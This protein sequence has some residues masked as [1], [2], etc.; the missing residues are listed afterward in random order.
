MTRPA[1]DTHDARDRVG[2]RT[3]PSWHKEP[4]SAERPHE[5]AAALV[6]DRRSFPRRCVA[7]YPTPPP[8]G[9]ATDSG[10]LPNAGQELA[11]QAEREGEYVPPPWC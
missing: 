2:V 9:V 3:E 7:T 5:T 8:G 11:R 1:S 10:D 6:A 4:P